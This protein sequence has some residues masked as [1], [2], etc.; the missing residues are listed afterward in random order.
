MSKKTSDFWHGGI[1]ISRKHNQVS[2]N[3]HLQQTV[4][5]GEVYSNGLGSNLE[6]WTLVYSRMHWKH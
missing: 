6:Y 4:K 1:W 2:Y 3:H 5:Y